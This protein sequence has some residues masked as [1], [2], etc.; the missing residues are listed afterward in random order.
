MGLDG[1]PGQQFWVQ[2]ASR[3]GGSRRL[4]KRAEAVEGLQH[5]ARLQRRREDAAGRAS[6][7]RSTIS[8]A[9][10][11]A[12]QACTHSSSIATTPRPPRPATL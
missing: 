1:A 9:R 5:R 10:S 6:G 7:I 4:T 8:G 2:Q 11:L 12:M 3:R